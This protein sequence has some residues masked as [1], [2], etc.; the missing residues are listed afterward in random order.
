MPAL[1]AGLTD[2]GNVAVTDPQPLATVYEITSAPT[3]TPFAVPDVPI[4]TLPVL[5]LHVPPAVPELVYNAEVA[6]Q[7]VEGP[8]IVPATARLFTVA[9]TLV[10]HPSDDVNVMF[11]VP[12]P[13]PVSTPDDEPIVATAVLELDHVP[14]PGVAFV[15]VVE[16]LTHILGADGVMASAAAFTVTV[17]D[18]VQVPIA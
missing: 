13:V 5:V 1:G 4:V 10:V 15:K 16:A 9:T 6:W 18:V 14:P 11:V 7:M 12:L 8:E 17:T 2:T 3:V